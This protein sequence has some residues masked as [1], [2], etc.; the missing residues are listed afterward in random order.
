MKR[1]KETRESGQIEMVQGVSRPTNH[2]LNPELY[3]ATWGTLKSICLPLGNLSPLGLSYS[4]VLISPNTPAAWGHQTNKQQWLRQGLVQGL[5]DCL[6]CVG[7]FSLLAVYPS[8]KGCFSPLFSAER[9]L[10]NGETGDV[11]V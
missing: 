2:V 11:Q 4:L 1:V 6:S 5:R 8:P 3:T 10:R 9:H 7:I